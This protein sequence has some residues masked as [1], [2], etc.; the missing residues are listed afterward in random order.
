[1]VYSGINRP[2]K[3]LIVLSC[4]LLLTTLISCDPSRVFDDMTRISN[5]EWKRQEALDFSFTIKDTTA[6]YNVYIQIRNT[7]DYPYS[8]L[9]LFLDTKEPSGI[10]NRDTIE[11]ILAAPDGKWLGKGMGKI[12]ENRILVKKGMQWARQGI[13]QIKVEQAMRKE[14]LTGI[15]DIGLRIEKE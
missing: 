14:V 13:Y 6:M 2:E 10:K 3:L 1:M 9:Y 7:T 5:S 15:A 12:K 4:L 11:C 8:N